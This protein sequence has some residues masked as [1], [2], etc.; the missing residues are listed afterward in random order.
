MMLL[1]PGQLGVVYQVMLTLSELLLLN[2]GRI[3]SSQLF[4]PFGPFFSSG[5]VG[6]ADVFG[7]KEI[8]FAM[9]VWLG[10]IGL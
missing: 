5:I 3:T 1:S 7:D 2:K 8:G 4:V 10:W 9:F 6:E